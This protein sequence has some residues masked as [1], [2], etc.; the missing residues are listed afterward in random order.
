MRQRRL[1]VPHPGRGYPRLGFEMMKTA[2]RRLRS[3]QNAPPPWRVVNPGEP[4]SAVRISIPAA[5]IIG[6]SRSRRQK[7]V[8]THNSCG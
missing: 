3:I 7:R 2:R 6:A 4:V 5:Q 8:K 1:T